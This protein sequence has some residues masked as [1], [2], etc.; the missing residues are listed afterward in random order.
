MIVK[1]L[2]LMDIFVALTFWIFGIFNL[3]FLSEF[4]FILGIILLIKGVIFM[5]QLSIASILDIIAALILIAS[6]STSVAMPKLVVIIIAL[7]LLSIILPFIWL[8]RKRW[9]KLKN[10]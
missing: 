2:G 4:I 10:D 6:S 1:I 5:T 8:W 3:S 9:L 7:V